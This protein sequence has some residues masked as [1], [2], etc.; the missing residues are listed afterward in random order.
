MVA[1]TNPDTQ[2]FFPFVGNQNNDWNPTKF[3]GFR[4]VLGLNSSFVNIC[5]IPT[6]NASI[7]VAGSTPAPAE[8]SQQ[9]FDEFGNCIGKIFSFHYADVNIPEP[10]LD[11]CLANPTVTLFVSGVLLSSSYQV[12]STQGG[13]KP[14]AFPPTDPENCTFDATTGTATCTIET[15][16]SGS[17]LVRCCTSCG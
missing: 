12:D 7:V 16:V 3:S 2:E 15:E 4:A 9:A 1:N 17:Q 6:E 8:S 10:K 14:S 5:D 13:G 11:T